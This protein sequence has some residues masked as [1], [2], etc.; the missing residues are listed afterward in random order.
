MIPYYYKKRR[1]QVDYAFL[2]VLDYWTKYVI[3]VARKK[4]E[5]KNNL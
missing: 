3:A 5:V 4:E 2:K 1:Y